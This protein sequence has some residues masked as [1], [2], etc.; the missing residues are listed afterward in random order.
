MGYVPS[1]YQ[2]LRPLNESS[3]KQCHCNENRLL[4]LGAS[5]ARS[6]DIFQKLGE[7]PS[8]A[9]LALRRH[10]L[11]ADHWRCQDHLR[12]R[13][14]DRKSET[15]RAMGKRMTTCRNGEG[16]AAGDLA[17]KRL[18]GLFQAHCGCEGERKQLKDKAE[19]RQHWVLSRADKA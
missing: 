9:R 16:A 11:R 8:L 10:Q 3:L 2:Q 7:H 4:T 17:R 12:G 5:T 15:G 6:A 13:R 19:G 18:W 14:G 1:E